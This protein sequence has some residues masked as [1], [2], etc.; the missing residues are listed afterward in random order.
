[1]LVNADTLLPDTIQCPLVS[2]LL[3]NLC[4]NAENRGFSQKPNKA[5]VQFL[6]AA[7]DNAQFLRVRNG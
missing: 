1:M 2:N 4:T 5:V 6:R 3:G 7:A